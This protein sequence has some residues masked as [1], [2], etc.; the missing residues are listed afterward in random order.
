MRTRRKF[1]W[2]EILG[3]Q[4]WLAREL[5]E[6]LGMNIM[7]MRRYLRFAERAGTLIVHKHGKLKYYAGRELYEKWKEEN[8]G[9]SETQTEEPFEQNEREKEVE[10]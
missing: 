8:S 5:A 1:N 2:K 10:K 3:N 4:A 6:K 7:T 9:C